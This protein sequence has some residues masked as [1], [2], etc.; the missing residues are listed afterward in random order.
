MQL[1]RKM[2][3]LIRDYILEVLE[4]Y[5]NM[6]SGVRNDEFKVVEYLKKILFQ[7]LRNRLNICK[8]VYNVIYFGS[9]IIRPLYLIAFE[10]LRSR[11]N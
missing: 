10:V 6:I 2:F 1:S 4:M 7:L 8:D 3:H 9:F 11:W 5:G